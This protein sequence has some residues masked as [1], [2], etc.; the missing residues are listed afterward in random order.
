MS[1]AYRR[2]AE[3]LRAERDRLPSTGNRPAALSRPGGFLVPHQP[4]GKL[5]RKVQEL[6]RERGGYVVKT[7]S[8][9]DSY[10]AVGTPDLLCCIYGQFVGIETK[11]PGEKLRKMQVVAL[12]EIFAAGGVAAVVE[13]V[14]QG[15]RLLSY[16]EDRRHGEKAM[17]YDRG[18]CFDRGAV[19]RK[20]TLK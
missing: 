19:S 4:E 15:V 7:H 1:C 9:E 17:G 20:F 11:L 13:T 10:Q 16:L 18:L 12:H 5:H 3:A 14:G 6:I 2:Y 8:S